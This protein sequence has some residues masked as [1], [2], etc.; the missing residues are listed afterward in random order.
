MSNQSIGKYSFKSIVWIS[1]LVIVL[2]LLVLF[3]IY[4]F[5]KDFQIE[6]ARQLGRQATTHTSMMLESWIQEQVRIVKLIAEDQR[7]I[8]AC[9]TPWDK[10]KVASA[11]QYLSLIH[12]RFPYY[13]NVPLAAK[14]PD[15][16]SFT[17]EVNGEKRE[18][19]SGQL[20][21]DTVNGNTIGVGPDLSFISNILDGKTYYISKVYKSILRGNPIFVISH[22]VKD[23]NDQFIGIGFITPQMTHFTKTFVET[24]KVGETGYMTFIDERPMTISHPD[25][26]LILNKDATQQFES[27]TSQMLQSNENEFEGEFQGVKKTYISRRIQLPEEHIEFNWYLL[28]T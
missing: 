28:F 16:F 9:K 25:D 18:I 3:L 10:E 1:S 14:L 12:D 26:S 11:H 2:F 6:S 13:E 4:K 7:V 20:F 19:Q 24:I 15:G 17:V 8:E 5:E 23:E 22:A 27:I 21:T